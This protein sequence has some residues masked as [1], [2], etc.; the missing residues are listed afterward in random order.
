[1]HRRRRQSGRPNLPLLPRW[2]TDT[3]ISVAE[4][5]GGKLVPYPDAGWNA[6]RN[7]KPLTPQ[8]HF[9]CVQSVTCDGQGNLWVLDPAAPGLEFIIKGGPKLVKID[10]RSNRVV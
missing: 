7:I 5:K 6:W 4:L 9:V 3:A 2:E 10:L 8:D 1:M